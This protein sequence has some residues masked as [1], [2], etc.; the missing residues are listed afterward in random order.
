ML[1]IIFKQNIA[2]LKQADPSLLVL[3]F[4]SDNTDTILHQIAHI[5]INDDDLKN[6]LEYKMGNFQVESLFKK[7]T[8]QSMYHLKQYQGTKETISK[9]SIYLKHT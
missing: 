5:P 6:Y 2:I 4:K 7:R 3:P 8:M 1:E 9:F